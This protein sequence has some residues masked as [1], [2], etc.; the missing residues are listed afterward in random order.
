MRTESWG[1]S[2]VGPHSNLSLAEK[3]VELDTKTSQLE[4]ETNALAATSDGQNVLSYDALKI[5]QE[6]LKSVLDGAKA[7]DSREALRQGLSAID[8]SILR[9]DHIIKTI[10]ES[11][12]RIA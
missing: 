5:K 9:Y 7:R 4:R 3:E 8:R 12:L 10:S 1:L 2:K 11:P 6:Y